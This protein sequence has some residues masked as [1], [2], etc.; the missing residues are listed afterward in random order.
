MPPRIFTVSEANALLP[1]MREVLAGLKEIRTEIREA[2][3]Q[4]QILDAL[5]GDAVRRPGNPDHDEFLV[6]RKRIR[7][8]V[9]ELEETVQDEI[10]DRGVRFPVGAL[11][12]G[13]LDFPT[14]YQGRWVY[15]CW[16][17]GEPEIQQWHEIHAGF[18]GRRE[19][20]EEQARVMGVV[21]GPEDL[22]PRPPD[23]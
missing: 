6:H 17:L 2:G 18:R 12:E 15:L 13:L 10:L 9:D 16:R 22:P 7:T 14:S 23:V 4:L 5:W 8:L 21:D 11:E 3:E 19:L 1:R 20:T